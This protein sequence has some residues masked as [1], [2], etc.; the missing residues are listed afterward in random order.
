MI[1]LVYSH[2][3]SSLGALS[4]IYFMALIINS[5]LVISSAVFFIEVVLAI[6][7]T[8]SSSKI[9]AIHSAENC[10]RGT[11]AQRKYRCNTHSCRR[12]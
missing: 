5:L 7:S 11:S 1:S 3:E 12:Q 9:R 6:A 10:G 8:K 4:A 2:Y